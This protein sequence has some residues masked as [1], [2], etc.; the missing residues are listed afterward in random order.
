MPIQPQKKLILITGATSGIGLAAVKGLTHEGHAVIGVARSQIKADTAKHKILEGNPEADITFLLADLSS[1]D[2]I[3]KLAQDVA[4]TLK[5]MNRDSID[6]LINNAGEV[7]SWY[8]LTEDGYERQ[9]AVNH[10]ASFLMTQLILPFLQNATNA[11][12]LTTSSASHRNARINW[13]DVMYRRHYGTLK[14]YKQSKLANV[15]FTLEFNRRLGEHA[16]IKSYAVDPGLVNTEIGAKGTNGFVNWFWNKRKG[17]GTTPE[18]AA[19]TIVYLA[20]RSHLPYDNE[21]YFKACHPVKPSRY[22]RKIDPA[23]RLWDLSEKLT[24]LS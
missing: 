12:V 1:Q 4:A 23:K 16:S 15:L 17:R 2:Q 18:I 19:E 6:V 3:H 14:A 11:K 9:F 22:A 5:L 21:W 8:T 7:S 13:K 20:C 24:G 10:L